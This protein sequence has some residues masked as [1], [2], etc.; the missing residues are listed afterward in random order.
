MAQGTFLSSG[1]TMARQVSHCNAQYFYTKGSSYLGVNIPFC[2]N[3]LQM[4]ANQFLWGLS[5]PAL[6]LGLQYRQKRWSTKS[7][8]TWLKYTSLTSYFWRVKQAM[9][10]LLAHAEASG[11]AKAPLCEDKIGNSAIMHAIKE[12]SQVTADPDKMENHVELTDRLVNRIS[13]RWDLPPIYKE[14]VLSKL[15][16]RDTIRSSLRTM[17][18]RL[19]KR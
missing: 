18:R 17:R 8:H 7:C 1:H 4:T 14:C 5:H 2:M 6:S 13:P 11:T 10:V 12:V 15:L 19:Q 9:E 3:T 16:T